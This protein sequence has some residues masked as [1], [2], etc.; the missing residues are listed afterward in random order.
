VGATPGSHR[1]L[2]SRCS[3]PCVGKTSINTVPCC[4]PRHDSLS[5]AR[6][7]EMG[8]VGAQEA[9]LSTRRHAEKCHGE[10]WRNR[11]RLHG[12]LRPTGKEQGGTA[13]HGPFPP[14]RTMAQKNA[15]QINVRRFC[16]ACVESTPYPY[17][18]RGACWRAPRACANA[19]CGSMSPPGGQMPGNNTTSSSA[20]SAAGEIAASQ[21]PEDSWFCLDG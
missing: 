16:G 1:P 12:A 5:T 11:H 7:R 18:L 17:T 4:Q 15:N 9:G 14:W 2:A 8:L 6:S 10:P 3:V 20:P 19:I 13:R 21:P